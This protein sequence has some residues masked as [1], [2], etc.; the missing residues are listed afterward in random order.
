MLILLHLQ[1]KGEEYSTLA[2]GGG[3]SWKHSQ[4]CM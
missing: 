1:K 3:K 2:A 4:F